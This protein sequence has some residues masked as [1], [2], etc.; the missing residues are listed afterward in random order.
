MITPPFISNKVE[1]AGASSVK[2]RVHAQSKIGTVVDGY[3]QYEA[4]QQPYFLVTPSLYTGICGD[5]VADPDACAISHSSDF[6]IPVGR[7]QELGEEKRYHR[8]RNQTRER[9][10][11]CVNFRLSNILVSVFM[12]QL[13]RVCDRN[14]HTQNRVL[15]Q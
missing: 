15:N 4:N 13:V 6:P 9:K 12:L 7:R 5:R 1:Q 11:E 3:A 14:L 8:S 2:N 10:N